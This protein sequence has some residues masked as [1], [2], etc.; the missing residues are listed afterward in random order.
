MPEELDLDRVPLDR[1]SF[2]TLCTQKVERKFSKEF[3][4][5]GGDPPTGCKHTHLLHRL[6]LRRSGAVVRVF[7]GRH[8]HLPALPHVSALFVLVGQF[9]HVAVRLPAAEAAHG[10]GEPLPQSVP[11]GGKGQEGERV[12]GNFVL[13][14]STGLGGSRGGAHLVVWALER[15]GS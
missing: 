3:L 4:T 1:P 14:S 15:C 10:A 6:V 2:R 5:D 9:L 7:L 12:I 8:G 11:Y 13:R